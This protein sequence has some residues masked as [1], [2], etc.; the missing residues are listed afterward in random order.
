VQAG[1]EGDRPGDH[2]KRCCEIAKDHALRIA[3]VSFA[4][5]LSFGLLA[6]SD[7][8]DELHVL[9]E[10]ISS[11]AKELVAAARERGSGADR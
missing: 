7:A 8:V 4:G 11:A 5:T 10:A 2:G 6:D 9:A 1:G 3:V